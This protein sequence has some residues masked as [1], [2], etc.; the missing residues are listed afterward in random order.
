MNLF[1][2]KNKIMKKIRFLFITLVFSCLSSGNVAFAQWETVM[3]DIIPSGIFISPDYARDRTLF[4]LDN[5]RVLWRSTNEGLTW[6]KSLV[7][8]D[9]STPEFL[10]FEMS[11]EFSVDGTAFIIKSNGEVLITVDSGTSWNPL[12]DLPAGITDIASRPVTD[13]LQYI[14]ALTALGG[15][16]NLFVTENFW[17][18]WNL[19][20]NLAAQSDGY[21]E[22]KISTEPASAETIAILAEKEISLSNDGGKNFYSSFNHGFE[23]AFSDFSFS[24]SYS[25]DSTLY[26]S[27][28]KNVWI[29]HHAGNPL[30]WIKSELQQEKLPVKIAITP[31]DQFNR[32]IY[33]TS[34][35]KVVK[36]SFD[37]GGTW[38]NF[39]SP[40][41]MTTSQIA[42]TEDEPYVV[43]LGIVNEDLTS[44]KLLKSELING[45]NDSQSFQ[46][47]KCYPNPASGETM[48]EF[49]V[50]K[51]GSIILTVFDILGNT[52]NSRNLG[53][54]SPGRQVVK[55]P[56]TGNLA[57]TGLYFCRLQSGE[58]T[59]T[60]KLAVK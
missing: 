49:A 59:C 9:M 33:A 38:E 58:E 41:N 5:S 60:V 17:E 55:I 8:Q 21:P 3:T 25:Q 46:R 36:R 39:G 43:F 26:A 34:A 47:M 52:V 27:D 53:E 54:F 1:P 14:F 30:T 44:G 4:V 45:I 35:E 19:V 7:A 40:L 22:L 48:L 16:E 57:V 11:G 6:T 15:P 13:Q 2:V 31:S 24:P 32:T 37:D 29:N 20:Q 10:R 50:Q 56:L 42:V 51:P 12:T 23:S 28:L 18:S